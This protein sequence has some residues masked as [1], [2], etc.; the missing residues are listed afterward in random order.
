[1]HEQMPRWS[2]KSVDDVEAE[3]EAQC[4]RLCRRIEDN[5]VATSACLVLSAI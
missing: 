2:L 4:A 3:V 5:K 1:M